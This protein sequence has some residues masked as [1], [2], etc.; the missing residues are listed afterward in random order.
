V[1]LQK[2]EPDYPCSVSRDFFFRAHI[3]MGGGGGGGS[4]R[5]LKTPP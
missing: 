4:L 3:S 5:G 1:L 2:Q